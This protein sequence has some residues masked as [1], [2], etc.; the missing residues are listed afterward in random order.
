[1]AIDVKELTKNKSM[2]MSDEDIAKTVSK[3]MAKIALEQLEW[4]VKANSQVSDVL[5]KYVSKKGEKEEI[6]PN[7]SPNSDRKQYC[8]DYNTNEISYGFNLI[9]IDYQSSG[10]LAA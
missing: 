3:Y 2:R 4:I 5:P 1:M 6:D 9:S 8:K 7:L 10:D